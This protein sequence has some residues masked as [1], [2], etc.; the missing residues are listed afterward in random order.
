MKA[1]FLPVLCAAAIAPFSLPG[2]AIA[3]S[4]AAA[5]MPLEVSAFSVEPQANP[6]DVEADINAEIAAAQAA[7]ADVLDLSTVPLLQDFVNEDGQMALPMDLP[8]SITIT[9]SF[10]DQAY[11]ID[12]RF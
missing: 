8:F 12:Y 1:F 2:A 11:G 9:D 6:N 5:L 10:G 7:R 4:P 3:E